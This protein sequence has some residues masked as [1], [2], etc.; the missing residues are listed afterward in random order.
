MYTQ[1]SPSNDNLIPLWSSNEGENADENNNSLTLNTNNY[2]LKNDEWLISDI[3]N[4]FIRLYDPILCGNNNFQRSKL[5]PCTIWTTVEQICSRLNRQLN[6][7]TWYVQY[8]GDRLKHLNSYDKPLFIQYEYLLSIGFNNIKRIQQEGQKHDLGYLIRFL[9]GRLIFDE[10][11]QE[12]NLSTY[13]WIRKGKFRRKWFKR[14]CIISNCRLTIYPDANTNPFV[15]ELNRA[16]VEEVR[17]KEKP[18]CLKLS[19]DGHGSLYMALNNDEEYS[20]WLKRMR[21]TTNKV[22]DIADY[23]SSHLELIPQNLFINQALSVLNLRHNNLRLRQTEEYQYTVGWLDDICRFQ[24]LVSLNLADNELKQFPLV[25]CDLHRLV[26]LNLASNRITTIAPEIENLQCLE[27]LHLQ[28]NCI[29]VLPIEIENLKRLK[30]ISL[31]F[32]YF[33]EIPISLAKLTHIRCSHVTSLF[34]AGN[35][36]KKITLQAIKQ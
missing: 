28:N 27:L 6:S 3:N 33:K 32:N 5:I 14:K 26:E 23:S 8:N 21:K 17:L 9:T 18:Y 31:A 24:N 2:R 29:Y 7:Q 19:V 4:G 12:N 13:V 36:I 11:L 30:D 35:H 16:N 10:K 22:I 1:L 20:Q 15:V 34:L 25:I